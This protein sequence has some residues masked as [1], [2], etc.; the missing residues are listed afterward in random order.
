VLRS[1]QLVY[2]LTAADLGAQLRCVAGAGDGPGGSPTRAVSSS[3]N[4]TVSSS[5]SCAPR[6]LASSTAPQPAVVEPGRAPCLLAPPGPAAIEGNQATIAV[7]RARA[8]IALACALARGCRGVLSLDAGKVLIGREKVRLGRGRSA[9]L[10]V[11]LLARGRRQLAKGP[12]A[13]TLTLKT[14]AQRRALGTA[15]L[16][17]AG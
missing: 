13:V 15:R 4:Y 9:V 14:R 6:R 8:A 10:H 17:D 16:L 11:P 1:F 7:S 3:P 5:R 2:N 12:L